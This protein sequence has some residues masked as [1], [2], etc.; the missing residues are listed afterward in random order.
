MS[1]LP[2][3]LYTAAQTRELDRRAQATGISAYA[4]MVRAGEAAFQYLRERWPFATR[5]VV[6]A[7]TW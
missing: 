5:I 6:L 4:L 7:G 3:S 1:V 2:R